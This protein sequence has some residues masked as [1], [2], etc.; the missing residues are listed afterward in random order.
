MRYRPRLLAGRLSR[1]KAGGRANTCLQTANDSAALH[2]NG[3]IRTSPTTP[4]LDVQLNAPG[5][6]D[7]LV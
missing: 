7:G 1:S 2:T 3:Q 5:A 4:Q 6:F